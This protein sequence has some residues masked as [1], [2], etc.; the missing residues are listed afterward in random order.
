VT[1]ST[2]DAAVQSGRYDRETLLRFAER[3]D[4]RV[5]A[6]ALVRS[7]DPDDFAEYGIV[8]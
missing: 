1:S 4:R 7:L 6:E 2:I 5:F 8:G 3:A